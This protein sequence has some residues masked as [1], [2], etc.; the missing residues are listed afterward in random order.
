MTRVSPWVRCA[1]LSL[2]AALGP[3]I[4][5]GQELPPEVQVDLYLVRAERHIQ[6]EDWP[7]A[8]EALDI[9]LLLQ[10]DQGMGT[11][12]ELWFTHARAALEAGFPDTA[13][14][15]ATR[16]L[17]EVGRGGGDYE[18]ALT[19][20]DEAMSRA[21][22]DPAPTPAPPPTPAPREAVPTPAP[23]PTP[24]PTPSATAPGPGTAP[25]QVAGG[26]SG[27]T[28]LFPL[29]GMNAS[30]MAVTTGDPATIG[31]S[32]VIGVGGGFGVAFPVSGRFGV[33][34][35]AQFAQKGAR[36]TLGGGN[37]AA[38]ADIAFKN[39]DLTALAR[40]PV[41]SAESLSLFALAGPYASFELDCR[42]VLDTGSGAGRFTGSDD[43]PNANLYTRPIDFG[44]SGGAGIEV[45]TGE[46]RVTAGL[47]YSYG[48]RDIDKYAGD[49][50]RHRV[51]NIHAGVART[52]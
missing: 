29:V 19:L 10:A 26:S 28:V 15:S 48:I 9:V 50:A 22:G 23:T 49:T 45:G 34:I 13:I 25:E 32:Q 12:A 11:P 33:Q 39:V 24:P 3:A 30:T 14:T 47:L 41:L 21:E 18:A 44:V 52:F 16:Y 8:L 17:R 2:A 42:L 37:I 7:A 43:C 46:T 4:A 38:N 1:V 36:A 27:F 40:I 5:A 35:G 31:A 6:N 51:F 20:L